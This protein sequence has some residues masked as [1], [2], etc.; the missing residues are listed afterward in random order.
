MVRSTLG[1]VCPGKKIA[2]APPTQLQMIAEELL[3]GLI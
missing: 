1:G 3:T 2:A